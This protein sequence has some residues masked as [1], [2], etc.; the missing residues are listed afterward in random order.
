MKRTQ[1]VKALESVCLAIDANPTDEEMKFVLIDN[2]TLRTTDGRTRIQVILEESTEITCLASAIDLLT[3]MKG[4][5]EEN[6]TL[7]VKDNKL[8]VKDKKVLGKFMLSEL[9]DSKLL[10]EL[11]FDVDK[12]NDVPNDLLLGIKF[13]QFTAAKDGSEKDI[14]EGVNI[15]GNMVAS[16]DTRRISVYILTE[17]LSGDKDMTIPNS[18]ISILDRFPVESVKQWARKGDT[19]YFKISDNITIAT[20]L[21]VSEDYPKV[22]EYI[23]D[24]NEKANISIELP[25]SLLS[26]LT[27][28]QVLQKKNFFTDQQT[29]LTFVDND[30]TLS[31]IVEGQFDLSEKIELE[32]SCKEDF[33]FSINPSFLKDILSKTNNLFYGKGLDFVVFKTDNFTHLAMCSSGE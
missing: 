1:F 4:L 33:S 9:E 20:Q 13:C 16:S 32:D 8:I 28:H 6:V 29:K 30:L 22:S 5:S 15:N 14:L 24:S 23:K 11:S 19:V 2:K 27:K 3:L 17:S 12:W 25:K 26:S 31:T 10:K 21:I 18:M 7:K